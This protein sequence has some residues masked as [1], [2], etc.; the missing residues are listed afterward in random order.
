MGLTLESYNTWYRPQYL[1][2]RVVRQ[3]YSA[4]K[5]LQFQR[6][7]TLRAIRLAYTVFPSYSETAQALFS[8]SRV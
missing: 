7:R 4:G 3:L 6:L 1:P 8:M 5:F 2:V